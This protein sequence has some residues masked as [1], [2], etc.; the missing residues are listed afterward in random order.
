MSAEMEKSAVTEVETRREGCEVN[1]CDLALHS[2]RF[3]VSQ[4]RTEK[5]HAGC[6]GG[7]AVCC[8]SAI[9]LKKRTLAEVGTWLQ[10]G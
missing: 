9:S 6:D 1:G 7:F 8:R 10:L 2:S 5:L 4:R 3:C